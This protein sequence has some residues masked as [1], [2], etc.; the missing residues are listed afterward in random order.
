MPINTQASVAILLLG[1]VGCSPAIRCAPEP[2][3][4]ERRLSVLEDKIR[5]TTERHQCVISAMHCEKQVVERLRTN[6]LVSTA[7]AVVSS[8][9][10]SV[11]RKDAEQGGGVVERRLYVLA[12]LWMKQPTADGQVRDLI[13]TALQAAGLRASEPPEMWWRSGSSS[14]DFGFE[15]QVEPA[16]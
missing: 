12:R 13:S 2:M 9:E 3:T 15:L 14:S 11:L 8:E 10:V 7:E 16:K 6:A 4:P 1:V 5:E